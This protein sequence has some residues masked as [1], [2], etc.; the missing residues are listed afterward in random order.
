MTIDT[1]RLE[2]Y[3]ARGL[4]QR[5]IAE[6]FG[7]TQGAVSQAMKRKGLSPARPARKVMTKAYSCPC[8]ESR[9]E[10]FYGRS[11]SLCRS[12]A[13]EQ[14]IERRRE[15]AKDTSIP[16]VKTENTPLMDSKE[17]R[18]VDVTQQS[19]AKAVPEPVKR[20]QEKIVPVADEEYGETYAEQRKRLM[21]EYEQDTFD[22]AELQEFV[23]K[24]GFAA[25]GIKQYEG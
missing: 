4:S 14:R 8:G 10:E 18:Q 9:P 19:P 11:K 20:E 16:S 22:E 25:L 2:G 15:G 24:Y 7:C 3:L 13:N 1:D 21:R 12:C 23:E 17:I 6:K 5:A